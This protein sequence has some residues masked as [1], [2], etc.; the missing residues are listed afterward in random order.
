[1]SILFKDLELRMVEEVAYMEFEDK[2][3]EVK[4]FLSTMDKSDLVNITCQRAYEDGIFN[5]VL[6]DAWFH[7][8]LIIMCSNLEL[9]DE[10]KANALETYDILRSNG[11]V[12][13]FLAAMNEDLYNELYT[14]VVEMVEDLLTYKNT[15]AAVINSLIQD[16]P[17]Q[18]AAAAEMVENFD[19][20]KY[21][22]VV[23]FAKAANGGRDIPMK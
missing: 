5:P 23:D 14:N 1:M 10:D 17:K 6:L 19:P 9:D 7:L 3:I 18:A 15:A 21:Q 22:A 12:D 16:L 20:A 8:H 13:K 11:F 2:Q 4:Q